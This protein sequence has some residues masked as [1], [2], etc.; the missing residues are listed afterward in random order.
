MIRFKNQKLLAG[1]ALGALV[2]AGAGGYF[3][4]ASAE[5]GAVNSPAAPASPAPGAPMTFADIVQRVAPAV[6]SID[7][8]GK[9]GPSKAA[10][11]GQG[12]FTFRFGAPQG[13]GDDGDDQDQDQGQSPGSPFGLFGFPQLQQQAPQKMR[14]SGSG[15]FISPD[16]YIVTNN[17]VVEGADKI[18]V[19][20]KDGQDLHAHLIGTDAATDVAVIKVDGGRFPYVSFE[21]RAKPRVGD[22][23]IAVGN[24]FGLG[25]T[26]TAGIVSALGRKNV[27]DSNY[28]DYVQIDAPINRGNSGGPTFDAYGRVI[29]VNTAI[30]S[31]SGGSVG[32]GFDIPADVVAQVSRQLIEH[33]KVTR[34]YI[35][36]TVQPVTAEISESLG[37]HGRKGAL[38]ADLTPGGPAEQAG[39][40]P[41]DV[42]LGIDG[43]PVDSADDLTR[44]VAMVHP[45]EVARLEVMRNGRSVNV[46]VHSGLRPSE[47][48]LASNPDRP[49][50]GGDAEQGDL[51]RV[52][53]MQLQPNSHGGVTVAAVA[54][55]SDAADKGLARGDVILQAGGHKAASAADVASAV[56]DARK[57]GRDEVLLMVTHNGRRVF[58]PLKIG[59]G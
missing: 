27:A 59:Q 33:G 44:Q 34:G 42:V 31:P 13:G 55:D 22:W 15:F 38:I 8:E 5:D 57:D 4:R 40:Q 43:R 6:V 14:A 12:P 30:Y 36:A 2:L 54:A 45:G 48:V 53:G 11:S 56:A 32:I 39:L 50:R 29:G 52:L 18:T 17:H 28:V 16:G 3:A 41:G 49:F 7:I 35:G 46:E 9:A 51:G 58:L 24:P 1:A 37:L 26:A 20:T 47:A 10:Y 25:G 23:V 21:D 19:H